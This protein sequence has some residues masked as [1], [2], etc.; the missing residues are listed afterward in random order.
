LRLPFTLEQLGTELAQAVPFHG[1]DK[2]PAGGIERLYHCAL[3][4]R[5]RY[6]AHDAR[7]VAQKCPDRRAEDFL[8]NARPSDFHIA[9]LVHIQPVAGPR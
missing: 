1:A 6:D 3:S 4:P 9:S 2:A 5:F 7:A 8:L